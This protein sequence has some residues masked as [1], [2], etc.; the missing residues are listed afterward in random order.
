MATDTQSPT[1]SLGPS[2]HGRRVS[3]DEFAEAEF[4]EPW[5]YEREEGKL[6]VMAPEGVGHIRASNPWRDRLI[7]WQYAHPGVIEEV[8]VQAWVQP[9]GDYD[10]VGDIGVYLCGRPFD[11]PKNPP[12]LMFEFVS[13]GRES[14]ERDY[15]KKRAEYYQ[16]GVREYVIVNRF[17]RSVLVLTH[18]PERYSERWLRD[19][20][21]YST[22]LLPGLEVALTDVF[23]P[24]PEG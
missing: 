17:D 3:A 11:I 6:V 1:L 24:K 4:P 16:V 14:R 20:E 2:D 9:D 12:D 10:R 18:E 23:P 8:V 19:G 7:L 21:V 5:N 15:V 13:P 22:P